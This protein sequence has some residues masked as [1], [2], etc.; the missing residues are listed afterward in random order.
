M[1]RGDVLLEVN[2]EFPES[3]MKLLRPEISRLESMRGLEFLLRIGLLPPREWNEEELNSRANRVKFPLSMKEKL[4]MKLIITKFFDYYFTGAL[5]QGAT[6]SQV[7]LPI[8]ATLQVQT[9]EGSHDYFFLPS[10]FAVESFLSTAIP[11][12]PNDISS[13]EGN[14]Q[15]AWSPPIRGTHIHRAT[16]ALH[17]TYDIKNFQEAVRAVIM[18]WDTRVAFT[19]EIF[20]LL[21]LSGFLALTLMCGLTKDEGQLSRI[22]KEKQYKE[23]VFNLTMWP[24]D[25]PF[26]PPCKKCIAECAIELDKVREDSVSTFALLLRRWRDYQASDYCSPYI[27]EYIYHGLLIHTAGMG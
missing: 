6:A 22:F 27:I 18:G 11:A 12:G 26:A 23:N 17:E 24:A 2:M 13:K 7:V 19:P 21:S 14:P 10:D 3:T 1:E 16:N 20:K 9:S 8:I 5:P 25:Y 4:V 15:V